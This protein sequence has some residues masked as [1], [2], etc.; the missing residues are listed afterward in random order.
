MIKK[1][2]TTVNGLNKKIHENMKKRP[3]RRNKSTKQNSKLIQ[4]GRIKLKKK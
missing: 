1:Y 3:L 4:C 2:A